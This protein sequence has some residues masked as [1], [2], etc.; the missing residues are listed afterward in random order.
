MFRLDRQVFSD[1]FTQQFGA[2]NSSAQAGLT[3][4]L[5]QI[6]QDDANWA[7]IYC[8]AYGLATF[9]WETGHTFQPITERGPVSYFAKYDPGTPLG[10]RL[11]NTQPGDGFKYRG[12]GYVQ[13]T[14]RANYSHDGNLLGL[15]LV[16]NPDLAL[17]PEVAYRIAA[18]G[19]KEGWFTGHRLAAYFPDIGPPDY[20]AARHIIN[21]SDH[22]QDIADIAGK[23]ET[24]LQA[25]NVISTSTAAGI[26]SNT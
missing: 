21:A 4:V 22:A 6:E 11:G 25:A 13:V 17:Q 14:G 8:V 15:D 20:L 9:K 3:A 1:N 19:M 24:I 7:N 23:M 18:R 10:A 26:N 16:G 12:R 2:P 5:D